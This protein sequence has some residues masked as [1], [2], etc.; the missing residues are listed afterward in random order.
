MPNWCDNVVTLCHDDPKMIAAV[1]EA[2]QEGKLLEF[3]A[4][5]PA[6][7][8]REGAES[9]GGDRAAEYDAIRA[10]NLKRYGYKSWYDWSIANWGT[11]WDVDAEVTDES[12]KLVTLRFSSAWSPPLA[13]YAALE[14]QGFE[15]D[16]LYH[17]SGMDFA[18]RYGEG[19]ECTYSIRD[20][21][22]SEF[23][24][25]LDEEFGISEQFADM[26]DEE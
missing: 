11:K 3:A 17:E 16:A 7:L 20:A 22:A 24:Q 4:P 26:D 5:M 18:G 2:A 9:Y 25:R 12:A 14:R 21:L 10:D 23:G 13:A 15:V 6:E 19:V 1:I 8:R